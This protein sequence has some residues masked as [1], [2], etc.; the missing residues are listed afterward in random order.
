MAL[1]NFVHASIV[2]PPGEIPNIAFSVPDFTGKQHGISITLA[3]AR[4]LRD[5]LDAA[6]T[7]VERK[8]SR[9]RA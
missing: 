3:N 5:E 1:N 7:A 9:D 2:D 6:I 8:A 4:T